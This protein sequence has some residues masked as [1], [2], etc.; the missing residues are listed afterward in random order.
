[1]TKGKVSKKMIKKK[2][3]KTLKEKKQAKREKKNKN[4][5]D[6]INQINP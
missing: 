3:I 4:S 2:P 6:F 5:E 1:M